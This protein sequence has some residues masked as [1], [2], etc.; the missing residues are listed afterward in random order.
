MPDIKFEDLGLTPDEIKELV[1]GAQTFLAPV[2][3]ESDSE[4]LT[5]GEPQ[6]PLITRKQYARREEK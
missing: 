5:R 6:E 2:P 4:T 3:D 1:I